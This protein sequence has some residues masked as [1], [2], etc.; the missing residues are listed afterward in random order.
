MDH[1]F[2]HFTEIDSD[3]SFARLAATLESTV[4]N[5]SIIVNNK[6][7]TGIIRKAKFEKGLIMRAWECMLNHPVVFRKEPDFTATE[8]QFYIVCVLNSDSLVMKN[9]YTGKKWSISDANLFFVSNNAD[10][11][12]VLKAG[13]TVSAIDISVTAS[14][15]KQALFSESNNEYSNFTDTIINSDSPAVLLASVNP[16]DLAQF[17]ILHQNF[18]SGTV[19]FLKLKAGLLDVLSRIIDRVTQQP[20][21]VSEVLGG[22]IYQQKM[23]EV[24]KIINEHLYT[25]LP[26]IGIIARQMAMSHSTLKRYF[27]AAFKKNI[28]AYYLEL[29]MGLARQMMEE[30]YISVNEVAAMLGYEKVSHFILMFKKHYGVSPGSIKKFRA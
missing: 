19:N 11:D 20:A 2:I 29:K 13:A 8:R 17:N 23:Q 24:E 27:K 10:I 5:N 22:K 15:M 4:Q 12:F 1:A 9:N 30:K 3:Q 21:S 14:W 16:I 26:E 25:S 28:Y 18:I 6:I 7:S